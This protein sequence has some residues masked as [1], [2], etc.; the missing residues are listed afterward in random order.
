[1]GLHASARRK[2][3]AAKDLGNVS[4][5]K[6]K[7]PLR[8]LPVG[9]EVQAA[10]GVHFRVWAPRRKRVEILLVPAGGAQSEAAYELAPDGTGFFSGLLFDAAPGMLYRYRLDGEKAYPDPASRFQPEGPHGPVANR[11]SRS[12]RL[13]RQRLARHPSRTAKSSTKCMSGRL[14]AQGTWAA[15]AGELPKP[16]RVW[17]SLSWRSCRWPILP[18]R[19]AGGM[20]ASTSS[21]RRGST[22]RRTT[23][24]RFVDRAHRAGTRCDSRRG[25]QPLRPGGQLLHGVLRRLLHRSL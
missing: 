2:S 12:F 11:R 9:A 3:V 20:T 13:D 1:M 17:A 7:A 21:R 15:A 18:G 10:G 8:R 5:K 22:A 16:S 25:L 24:A 4:T 6:P 23:F 19:L 14:R